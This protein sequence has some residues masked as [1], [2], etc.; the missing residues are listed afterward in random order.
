MG[1]A[2]IFKMNDQ[3]AKRVSRV[4]KPLGKGGISPVYLPYI[5]LYLPTSAPWV[6]RS[7]R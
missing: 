2:S 1:Q 7:A 4:G 5:S 3:L 6:S